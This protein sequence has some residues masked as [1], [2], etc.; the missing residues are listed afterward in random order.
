MSAQHERQEK[1]SREKRKFQPI[2][3]E[4]WEKPRVS[5][6]QKKYLQVAVV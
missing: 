6:F 4:I 2:S 3:F 5:K 1:V